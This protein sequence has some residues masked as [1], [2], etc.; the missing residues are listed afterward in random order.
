[1]SRIPL[2]RMNPASAP[3]TPAD[4]ALAL[5]LDASD[6]ATVTIGTG[7]S[8]WADKSGNARHVSQ[9]TGTAQ[10]TYSLAA[11]N[12]LNVISFGG[13]DDK[14]FNSGSFN[15]G[16][17]FT[18]GMVATPHNGVNGYLLRLGGALTASWA[19]ISEYGPA[20]EV[21]TGNAGT[22]RFQVGGT[23]DT[24]YHTLV[25]SRNGAGQTSIYDGSASGSG[26]GTSDATAGRIDVGAS[27]VG[28]FSVA[29][30]AEIVVTSGVLSAG[31]ATAL[32]SYLRSKW[33]TP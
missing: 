31:D 24:G 1:M 29:S 3:F 26:S 21:Y 5:W 33:G 14:L 2:L 23:T 18:V 22:P 13:T 32:S 17:A 11:Q 7:V 27:D 8:Q 12:G 19:V 28:D 30:I 16:N 4:L 9:A 10:P 25:I 6:A 20:Y 15:F